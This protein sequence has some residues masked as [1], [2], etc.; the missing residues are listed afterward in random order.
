MVKRSCA[1]VLLLILL[2]SIAY[3]EGN[4][5]AKIKPVKKLEDATFLK[6]DWWLL[7]DL[8][9]LARVRV[10]VYYLYGFLD[11][12]TL[13][14]LKSPLIKEFS[15]A[16]EGMDILELVEMMNEIYESNPDM[17]EVM[18]V[19]MLTLWVPKIREAMK[20]AESETTG[21]D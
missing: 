13:W 19:F 10:Q 1:L 14:Q 11:A 5:R 20:Q 18:P 12:H 6:A 8:D 21:T 9:S 4:E 3:G 16:C 17:R 2:A 7:E 15:K